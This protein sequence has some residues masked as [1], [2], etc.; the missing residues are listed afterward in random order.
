MKLTRHYRWGREK[1][2]CVDDYVEYYTTDDGT[3]I[4]WRINPFN[5]RKMYQIGS[6]E[7]FYKTLKEVK[8]ELERRAT[9]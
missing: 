4:S 6:E 2:Y 7:K 1:R 5:Y 8:Q 3:V 9:E